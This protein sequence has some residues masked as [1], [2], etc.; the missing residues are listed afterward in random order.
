MMKDVNPPDERIDELL[1]DAQMHIVVLIAAVAKQ[2]A[3]WSGESAGQFRCPKCDRGEVL[4]RLSANGHVRVVC[5][6]VYEDDEG[7]TRRCVHAVE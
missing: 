4:W 1:T 7:Q 3:E 6:T 5:T 2:I